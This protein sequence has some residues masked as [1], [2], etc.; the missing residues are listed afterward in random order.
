MIDTPFDR[1]KQKIEVG[2]DDICPFMYVPVP[3]PSKLQGGPIGIQFNHSM[4]GKDQCR[5]YHDGKCMRVEAYK[6]IAQFK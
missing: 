2:K 6:R 5:L 4:C 3:V 1:N